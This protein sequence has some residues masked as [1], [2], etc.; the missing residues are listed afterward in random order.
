MGDDW[1]H[2]QSPIVADTNH[3]GGQAKDL[4]HDQALDTEIM[5]STGL[6]SLINGVRGVETE[7]R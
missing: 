4:R 7:H 3:I 6:A 1:Q 2:C 5:S